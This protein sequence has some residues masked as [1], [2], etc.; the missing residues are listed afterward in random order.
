MAAPRDAKAKPTLAKRKR[1]FCLVHLFP[2]H[3]CRIVSFSERSWQKKFFEEQQFEGLLVEGKRKR[4]VKAPT[5]F[6]H[7][8]P[9]KPSKSLKKR[10]SKKIATQK[11][12]NRAILP[13][14]SCFAAPPADFSSRE[15]DRVKNCG[16]RMEGFEILQIKVEDLQSDFLEEEAREPECADRVKDCGDKM[17]QFGVMPIKLEHLQCNGPAEVG[18]EE[19]QMMGVLAAQ[20]PQVL[21][22]MQDLGSELEDLQQEFEQTQHSGRD[23]VDRM[24]GK[25]KQLYQFVDQAVDLVKS[26]TKKRQKQKLSML[27]KHMEKLK[28][29]IGALQ[30]AKSPQQKA[31]WGLE[32]IS[33]LKGYTN[34]GTKRLESVSQ[35]QSVKISPFSMLDISQEEDNLDMLIKLNSN[36]LNE[37]Q[38]G[39]TPNLDPNSAHPRIMISQDLRTATRTR[40][41]QRYPEHPDRFD[42]YPQVLSSDSFSSGRHYWEVDVSSSSWCRIGVAFNSMGRKG[43]GNER[44][45]GWNSASWCL[46]KYYNQ[47]SAWHKDDRTLLSLPGIPDRFGFLLDCEAGELTCFG[48]SRVLH[49]FKGD[50]LNPVKP[51]IGVYDYV[52]GSVRFCSF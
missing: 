42:V 40:T 17:E 14:P 19:T 48:D 27:G 44:L 7:I 43:G 24:E 41:K 1:K 12:V 33:F 34:L 21:N 3:S 29:Q 30:Q 15:P 46:Q 36:I 47:Y 13:K 45:L 31:L 38:N 9:R 51:A 11:F 20:Y 49:V 10:S 16:V 26:R 23:T 25:R 32:D 28:E 8:K 18:R 6:Y 2:K 35:F 37:I 4:T 5:I 22:S 50:F 52:V 39:G